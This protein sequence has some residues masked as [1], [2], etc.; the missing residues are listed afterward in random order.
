MK[1][2]LT[3]LL[4]STRGKLIKGNNA[5]EFFSVST[6]T[7]KIY[8]GDIF[9]PLIGENFNGHNYIDEAVKK[10]CNAYF[11]DKNHKPGNENAAFIIQV[12]DTL[13]AYLSIARY[14]RDKYNPVVV[15][16]T[17]SSGK[18]TTKEF[19]YS[20]LETSFITHKSALNHNNEIGLCQTLLSMPENCEYVV[21]EMGMRGLGEISMLSEYSKPDIAVITNIGSAH[22]GRLGS[23]ENI[24]KAKCEVVD[25]L[26]PNGV[27]IASDDDLI[28][29]HCN[30]PGK[31]VFL[32]EEYEIIE[33]KENSVEFKYKNN[34]YLIPVTEKYNIINSIFAIELGSFAGIEL[35]TIKRELLSYCPV[36]DRGKVLSLDNNIKFVL[37]CYNANPESVMSS[38]DSLINSY[39]GFKKVLVL[40][41]M[42]ELGEFEQEKHLEIGRYIKGKNVDYLVTVGEKA[43]L[44]AESATDKIH[45]AS[46]SDNKQASD[47]LK[48]YLKN[49][50]V[51]LL[52]GSRCMKLEEIVQY[53]N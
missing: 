8:P 44:I 53:I 1:L 35:E 38:I 18:T 43:C 39:Q 42:A 49:D 45:T 31:K 15:A 50:T 28:K 29:T 30:F 16:V 5:P 13:T 10:G 21:I 24:A 2:S 3:E 20:V 37:D 9:L 14:V 36:G 51:V 7:R 46:F 6:D 41:D 48:T 22:I 17:G 12:E 25:F 47:F 34:N 26:G 32:Q 11:T 27:L 33:W 19:I 4:N 40:G 52:K 23:I